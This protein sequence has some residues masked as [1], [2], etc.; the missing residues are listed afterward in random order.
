MIRDGS[1][2]Q[3]DNVQLLRIKSYTIKWLS[4]FILG[5]LQIINLL[6]LDVKLIQREINNMKAF[7]KMAKW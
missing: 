3:K 6:D 7:G 2:N 4:G 5:V 1:L